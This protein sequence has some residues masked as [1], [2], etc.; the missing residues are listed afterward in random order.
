[1]LRGTK[2]N[3]MSIAVCSRS[4]DIIEPL[5]MPQWY[6]ACKELGKQAADAVRDG[7]LEIIPKS[8]EPRYF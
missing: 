8:Q 7:S 3:P 1:L 6:V 5:I 2:E 4:G